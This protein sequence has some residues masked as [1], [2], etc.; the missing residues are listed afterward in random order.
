MD[1]KLSVGSCSSQ[2]LTFNLELSIYGPT[3]FWMPKNMFHNCKTA[4]SFIF[5]LLHSFI[6]SFSSFIQFHFIS[7]WFFSFHFMSFLQFIQHGPNINKKTCTLTDP[8]KPFPMINMTGSI[9]NNNSSLVPAMTSLFKVSM[10]FTTLAMDQRYGWSWA[11]VAYK[12]PQVERLPTSKKQL[13]G[14]WTNPS[15]KYAIVKMGASSPRF[16]VKIWKMF[17]TTS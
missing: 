5:E 16:G 15:E 2:R 12:K 9:T 6:P 13:I 8:Q 4:H 7:F 1:E 17:E 3:T 11:G 14:G 10:T